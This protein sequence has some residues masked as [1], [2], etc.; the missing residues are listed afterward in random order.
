MN[1]WPASSFVSWFNDAGA[2]ATAVAVSMSVQLAVLVSILSGL[3]WLI[4][5]RVR[6]AFGGFEEVFFVVHLHHA[7]RM[8]AEVA[9]T[10]ERH[11]HLV[12]AA[13]EP[14]QQQF[15]CP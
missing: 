14:V 7:P 2:S 6:A 15:G 8:T 12:A 13:H 10:T 11:A 3:D 4:R 9:V 5:H 1:A